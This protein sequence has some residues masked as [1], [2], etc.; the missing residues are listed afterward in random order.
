MNLKISYRRYLAIIIRLSVSSFE[1]N[2][3]CKNS[4]VTSL[5]LPVIRRGLFGKFQKGQLT[6][7]HEI[8]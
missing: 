1:G 4:D 2:E 8:I 3:I 7:Q 5:I 6:S